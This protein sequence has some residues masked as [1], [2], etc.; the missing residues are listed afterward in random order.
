MPGPISPPGNL[1][2]I[3]AAIAAR[4]DFARSAVGFAGFSP[5]TRSTQFRQVALQSSLTPFFGLD[6]DQRMMATRSRSVRAS[7]HPRDRAYAR[8]ASLGLQSSSRRVPRFRVSRETFSSRG[9]TSGALPVFPSSS[10]TPF[11]SLPRETGMFP[12]GLSRCSFASPSL[13]TCFLVFTLGSGGCFASSCAS[14]PEILWWSP[15]VGTMP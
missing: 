1:S 12:D 7:S 13:P 9:A 10:C 14:F 4:R 2:P 5:L 6:L 8:S 3:P 15:N 11:P